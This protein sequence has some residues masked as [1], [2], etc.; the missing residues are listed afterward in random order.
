MCFYQVTLPFILACV[1]LNS[2]YVCWSL[3]H[4]CFQEPFSSICIENI[5]WETMS[6]SDVLA[7]FQLKHVILVFAARYETCHKCRR[8][9]SPHGWVAQP[10]LPGPGVLLL[11][12]KSLA[13]PSQRATEPPMHSQ[14]RTPWH[15]VSC[16][17]LS[18]LL[19]GHPPRTG[20]C[21]THKGV[22]REPFEQ[23]PLTKSPEMGL[24]CCSPPSLRRFQTCQEM[25]T[26]N[27]LNGAERMIH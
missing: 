13:A 2:V 10:R 21:F 11:P 12:L 5:T 9:V 26:G 3:I 4:N 23:G 25:G 1:G 14:L 19:H 18:R 7:V 6:L 20:L 8:A 24:I 15:P 27:D 17:L 22:W 16:G